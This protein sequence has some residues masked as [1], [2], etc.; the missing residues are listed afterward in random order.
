LLDQK[1]ADVKSL[2]ALSFASNKSELP[3]KPVGC[4]KLI[5]GEETEYLKYES[6]NC[7]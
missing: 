7:S 3:Q 4:E 6:G 2:Y 5:S 1:I